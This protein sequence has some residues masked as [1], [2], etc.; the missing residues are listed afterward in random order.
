MYIFTS[1]L[2]MIMSVFLHAR[3]HVLHGIARLFFFVRFTLSTSFLQLFLA[4]SYFRLIPETTL[5]RVAK[6]IVKIKLNTVEHRLVFFFS[7]RRVV[8]NF[9]FEFQT[10]LLPS[11][12]WTNLKFR[13]PTICARI[14]VTLECFCEWIDHIFTERATV[15]SGSFG[16]HES[17]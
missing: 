2:N 14:S 17:V 16:F 1:T 3:K 8:S 9:K 10:S 5:T 7:I 4:T 11:E 6:V 13:C 12:F 15:P